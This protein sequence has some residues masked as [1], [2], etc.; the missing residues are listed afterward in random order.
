MAGFEP[1]IE[2]QA[3]IDTDDSVVVVAGPGTGKTRTAIE[4]ARSAVPKTGEATGRQ[5]LF[6]SF[7]NAAIRRL[8][9][10]AGIELTRHARRH[11]RFLT[12]HSCALHILRSYGRFVGLPPTVRVLDT[13]EEK[14]ISID[15][16]WTERGDAYE[17]RLAE[18]A[19]TR[20][21][22][23]FSTIV[24]LAVHLLESCP[25]LRAIYSRAF[26]LIM[27]DE[28]QD[29]SEEQW[30]LL[31]AMGEASQVVAFA[32]P[33]QII[34]S[35]LHEATQRRLEEFCAWKTCESAPFSRQNYRCDS[36]NILDFA[37]AVLRGDRYTGPVDQ[38]VSV[39]NVQYRSRLR[40]MLA[41]IWRAIQDQAGAEQTIGFLTP[42]NRIAEDV[43]TALR[44][45]PRSGTPVFRV[46]ARIARDEAAHDAVMLALAAVRDYAILGDDLSKRKAG[47]ALMAMEL[48][49]NTRKRMVRRKLVACERLLQ[50]ANTG[51]NSHLAAVMN[52]CARPCNL[53][54]LLPAFVEALGYI[55]EFSGSCKRI[56]AHGTLG[57]A[58]VVPSDPE[59]PLF[60]QVRESRSPKGLQG[61]DAG[62][63]RTHVLNYHKAK[64]REFDFVALV[65]DPRGESTRPPMDERRRLYY[66]CATRA[67]KWLGVL[68]Y[69]ND[70]GPVLRPV[71]DL[72]PAQP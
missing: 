66:V 48:A 50:R 15:E 72:G 46:Y 45:P 6:L 58:R 2:Q 52:E 16:G 19:K 12:Y 4:K 11:V 30:R 69:G 63:G 61:Y 34:Y 20:G 64:G 60:D 43:A 71:L 53:R 67:K 40:S 37:D 10:A 51:D 44:N 68:R 55:D 9:E 57:G 28:F 31:K 32:D 22:L 7:S 17:G 23:A 8:S 24:P 33:N 29:T 38:D 25:R 5:V 59:L 70:V 14:L 35:S 39:F 49:W 21:L 41:V 36:R 27:V 1:T 56:A 18:L 54:D 26:P 62:R 65:V 3:V 42:N 47:V 13:L